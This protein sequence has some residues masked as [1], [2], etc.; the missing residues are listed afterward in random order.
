MTVVIDLPRPKSCL[1]GRKH[2]VA[3]DATVTADGIWFHCYCASTLF[4]RTEKE[5]QHAG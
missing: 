5:E 2:T 3:T 1:C 4:V